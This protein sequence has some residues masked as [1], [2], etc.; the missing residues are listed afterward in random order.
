[1]AVGPGS[2]IK[3][4]PEDVRNFINIMGNSASVKFDTM[5]KKKIPAEIYDNEGK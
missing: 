3:G 2:T 4:I 5:S 1:M